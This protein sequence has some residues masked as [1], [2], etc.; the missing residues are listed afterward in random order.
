MISKQLE[1]VL[2]EF[3]GCAPGEMAQRFQKARDCNLLPRNR[4]EHAVPLSSESIAAAI[5][6]VVPKRPSF[7]GLYGRA[8]RDLCP[9]GGVEASYSQAGSL[10]EAIALAIGHPDDVLELEVLDGEFGV[11]SYGYA[12]LYYKTGIAYFVQ[13]THL[14]LMVHGAELTFNPRDQI[15]E[16]QIQSKKSFSRK[17]FVTISQKLQDSRYYGSGC[18]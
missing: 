2:T 5:L 3:S 16:L 11:N 17:V 6:C 9:V 14:S 15:R 7:A 18:A 8:L 10:G 4:G 12:E 1:H 13:K